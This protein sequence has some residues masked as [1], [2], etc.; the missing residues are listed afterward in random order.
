MVVA[1]A[2]AESDPAAAERLLVQS[3]EGAQSILSAN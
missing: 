1:A 2:V 3:A